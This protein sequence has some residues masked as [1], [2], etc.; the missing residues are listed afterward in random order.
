[1]N[2]KNFSGS[3]KALF[4][5]LSLLFSP[6]VFAEDDAMGAFIQQIDTQQENNNAENAAESA[7]ENEVE[8]VVIQAEDD[9]EDAL[10]EFAAQLDNQ[11]N[12]QTD[13]EFA[14]LQYL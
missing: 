14:L 3:L 6:A 10:G 8:S 5:T 9:D 2:N 11:S 4:V 13:D 7:E 1:M 12:N